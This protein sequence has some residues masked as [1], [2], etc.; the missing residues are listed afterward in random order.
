MHRIMRIRAYL[1]LFCMLSIAV[2][3]ATQFQCQSQKKGDPLAKIGNNLITKEM[4]DAFKHMQKIYP[5]QISSFNYL[6]EGS[7]ISSVVRTELLAQEAGGRF[8]RNHVLSTHDWEWKSRYFPAQYYLENVLFK[9]M[10]ATDEELKAW[11]EKNKEQYKD[12]VTVTDSGSD[13]TA[14]GTKD[15]IFYKPFVNVRN[16]VIKAR[17]LEEYPPP[18]STY[19]KGPQKPDSSADSTL[20]ENKWYRSVQQKKNDFF[21]ERI[22]KKQTGEE[23]VDSLHVW[24]GEGKLITPEDMDVILSW[25][26]KSK[27]KLYTQDSSKLAYLGRWLLRWNLYSKEAQQRGVADSKESVY[28]VEWAKKVDGAH[29]YYEEKILPH[30]EKS[31][32]IDTAMARYAVLDHKKNITMPVD[33]ADLAKEISR[34]I[35]QKAQL[36]LDS[37]LYSLRQR[38]G[39]E[40]YQSDWQDA[41]SKDP[42]E[43][44]NQA[45]AL[46]DSGKSKEASKLYSTL[47]TTFSYTDEGKKAYTRLAKIQSEIGKHYRAIDN[48]R[49]YLVLYGSSLTEKEKGNVFFMIGFIYDEYRNW[50]EPAELNYKWVLKH[51][52][53]SELADDAEFMCLHLGEPM[54]SIEELR[55]QARRQGQPQQEESAQL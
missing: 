1:S 3:A 24:Y 53:D 23:Y 15:S 47:V 32:S 16:Q 4:F 29:T 39:V 51:T 6:M 26:P 12:T 7:A 35:N 13:T 46:R 8:I 22:Y 43:L 49:D 33:S 45:S 5:A 14:S 17:F 50:P 42:A 10:G 2:F 34:K 31:A 44:F 28:M 48:Y 18:D 19:I 38:R 36:S 55:A 27:R 25:L 41:Q 30:V 40:Y 54:C 11:Y 37:L 52:P 9:N 20:I 21:L